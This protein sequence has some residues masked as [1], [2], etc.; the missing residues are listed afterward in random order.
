[1][2]VLPIFFALSGFLIAGSLE[3]NKLHH[4]I[5]LR[6]LRLVPALAVEVILSAL[7]IGVLFTELPIKEYLTSRGFFTYFLN[8]I[9]IIHFTLPGVFEHN[10]SGP[11]I[12]GQLWT[13]PYELEGY[14]S[15]VFLS[16]TRL[17]SKRFA[18]F[19]IVM[20]LSIG[21]TLRLGTGMTHSMTYYDQ[22]PGRMLVLSCLAAVTIYLYRDRI[23]YSALLGVLSGVLSAV[24]LAMPNNVYLAIFPIAYFTIWVGMMSP[25]KIPFGDL[26]YGVY[27]FHY[28]ILQTIVHLVPGV[29]TWWLLTIVALPITTFCAWLSWNLI[30]YPI[31][32][33]KKEVLAAVD[34]TWIA[35]TRQIGFV[36]STRN[37]N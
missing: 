7:V 21:F 18:V 30:E 22:A 19:L 6:A 14:I 9:G 16:L 27:L 10:P 33:R 15:L 35:G 24:I 13:I 4:F 36:L 32:T 1:V 5:I 23:P 11:Y 25:P 2:S 12:N 26:S 17:I 29:N 28:P 37:R 31:L 8:I 20:G 3:R 34:R